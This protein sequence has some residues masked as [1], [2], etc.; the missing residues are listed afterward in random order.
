MKNAE[1]AKML[2]ELAEIFGMQNIPFKP[3]A[4]ER[5]SESIASLDED[6]EDIYKKGG[7]NAL[8]EIQGVG[9]GIAERIEEYIK[10]GKMDEYDKMKKKFPGRSRRAVKNSTISIKR[11]KRDLLRS[12]NL[13]M[14]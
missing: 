10:T 14:G 1:I 8:E 11:L 7:I 2:F 9:R 4:F 3:R 12:R 5:A 13:N 6:I